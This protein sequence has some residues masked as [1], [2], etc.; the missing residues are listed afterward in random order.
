[1]AE[2]VVG[3]ITL[4]LDKGQ[5]FEISTFDKKMLVWKSKFGLEAFV[6]VHDW[7][8][9]KQFHAMMGQLIADHEAE[10]AAANDVEAV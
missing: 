7:D 4:G 1:M 10:K 9:A 5:E 3:P 2:K 6:Y 8:T